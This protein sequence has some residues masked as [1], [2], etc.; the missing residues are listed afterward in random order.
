M[1]FGEVT[2]LFSNID[3]EE[4]NKITIEWCAVMIKNDGTVNGKSYWV[5]AGAEY[6]NDNEVWVGQASFT[7]RLSTEVRD[8]HYPTTILALLLAQS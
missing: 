7:A 4:A 2:N 3:E 8:Y 6:N 5:S 1:D